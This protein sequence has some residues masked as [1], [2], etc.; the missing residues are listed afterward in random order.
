M[1]TP[2]IESGTKKT[3][4]NATPKKPEK[5]TTSRKAISKKGLLAQAKDCDGDCLI[6]RERSGN[7][8]GHGGSEIVGCRR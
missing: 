1:A 2:K 7:G 8:S 5:I 6:R 3:S 4:S